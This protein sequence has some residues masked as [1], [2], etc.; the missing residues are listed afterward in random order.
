MRIKYIILFTLAFTS[1]SIYSQPYVKVVYMEKGSNVYNNVLPIVLANEKYDTT[2]GKR[3]MLSYFN[4]IDTTLTIYDYGIY[5][6][7]IPRFPASKVYLFYKNKSSEEIKYIDDY[8]FDSLLNFIIKF[9][10]Q[11]NLDDKQKVNLIY[12]FALFYDDYIFIEGGGGFIK[13][14]KK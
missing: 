2:N 11:N 10:S 14:K 12:N 3:P 5:Y 8:E 1:N 13:K 7:E 4:M 9:V 6:I